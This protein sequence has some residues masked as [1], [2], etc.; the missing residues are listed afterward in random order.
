MTPQVKLNVNEFRGSLAVAPNKEHVR[1]ILVT[2]QDRPWTQE[3]ARC[4]A[5]PPPEA[6]AALPLDSPLPKY[7]L[8]RHL[9]KFDTRANKLLPHLPLLCMGYCVQAK[10][11]LSESAR[12]DTWNEHQCLTGG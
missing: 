5:A 12:E 10:P 1:Q 8:Q 4:W 9:T 3:Q 7:L 6:A 11:S 2:H